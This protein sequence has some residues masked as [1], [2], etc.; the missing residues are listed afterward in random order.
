MGC[1]STSEP[2]IS[3]SPQ[4]LNEEADAAAD[5]I[6][7]LLDIADLDGDIEMSVRADRPFV[8]V[9]SE[10]PDRLE[11]LVGSEGQVLDAVQELARLAVLERTGRRTRLIIDIAGYR[12]KR[13]EALAAAAAEAVERVQRSGEELELAPMNPFERKMV[14]DAVREAGYV[15]M[16]RGIDPQRRVVV[17]PTRIGEEGDGGEQR[18]AR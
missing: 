6:E 5:Y 14:H 9:V 4:E 16:S 11:V 12:E 18:G 17:L 8:E 15:S 2:E 7:G 13:Q 10:H 1:V 3:P